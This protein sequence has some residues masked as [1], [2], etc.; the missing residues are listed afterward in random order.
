MS[1]SIL[2][3]IPTT[4][5]RPSSGLSI[6]QQLDGKTT[7]SMDFDIHKDYLYTPA[8]QLKLQKGTRLTVLYTTVGIELDFLRVTSWTSRD[9]PGGICTVSVE[10]EGVNFDTGESGVDPPERSIVFTRN[11]ATREEPIWNHPNFIL[12]TVTVREAIKAVSDG[13]AYLTEENDIRRLS[14]DEI[15]GSLSNE[16]H[17]EWYDLIVRRGWTTYDRATSEWTK[18]ATSDRKLSS[19]NLEKL[20]KIDTPPGSPAAPGDDVWKF[21]GATESINIVGEGS[22]SYSLTWT[23]GD[24]PVKIFG[25]NE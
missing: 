18:T 9:N 11:N 4:A 12:L 20:G 22:N 25:P 13:I 23:S 10:F 3:S 16:D 15:I 17:Q 1:K 21:S 5:L 14:N 24:W 6:N 19:A 7:A 2:Y 8:I